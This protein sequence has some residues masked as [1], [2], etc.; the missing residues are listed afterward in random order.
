MPRSRLRFLI[1]LCL[2]A[3]TLAVYAPVCGFSFVNLD[4]PIYV[5][6]NPLLTAGPLRAFTMVYAGYWIPMTWISYQIDYRAY[7][8]APGGYHRTNLVLHVAYVLLLF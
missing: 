2:A 3:A 1:A 4:D 8:L 6:D 5:Q 7:G